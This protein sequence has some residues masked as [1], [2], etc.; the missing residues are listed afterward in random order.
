MRH[1]KF[2]EA[3]RE[4][5]AQLMETHPEVSIIGLGVPTK[6]GVF[7]TT[8]GLVDRFGRDRVIDTPASENGITGAAVGMAISGLRPIVV[9]HRLD[10]ALL[11]IDPLVNQAAKWHYMYGGSTS[12]PLTVRAL[13]GRGWGQGPQH[14]QSLQSWFAHIP[15]LKV[16]MPT[17]P[18]DAKSLLV[19]AV[20]DP[21][22]VLVLEHRWLYDISGPVSLDMTPGELGK[23]AITR[24]GNDLTLVSSSYQTLE[25]LR[26]AEILSDMGADVEVIDLRSINPLDSSTVLQS[27]G[28]TGRLIVVD[29]AHR[30]CGVAGEILARVAEAGVSLSKP[31]IRLTFPDAPTPTTPALANLYYPRTI[32]I[33]HASATLLDL[34]AD[35]KD[36]DEGRSLDQPNPQ[37]TGPY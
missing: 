28:R 1:L 2:N 8:S 21:S 22:P 33:L 26:A 36:P 35:F 25:C 37:F 17:T 20:L 18:E 12:C 11:S 31:P 30:S 23:A 29:G 13:I 14:S 7:G 27:V 32:D 9:H 34:P 5:S 15:G 10:F 6:A 16:I 19:A 3:I 24:S 4:G